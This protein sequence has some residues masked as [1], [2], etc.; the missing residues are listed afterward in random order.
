MDTGDCR[1][2]SRLMT[3]VASWRVSKRCVG[4]MFGKI[5]SDVATANIQGEPLMNLQLR[6]SW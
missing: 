1:H 3:L 6:L 5:T 2:F 4:P